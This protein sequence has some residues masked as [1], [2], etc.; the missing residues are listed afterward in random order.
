MI[1][2]RI[3]E[4]ES[5]LAKLRQR[6]VAQLREELARLESYLD[7]GPRPAKSSGKGWAPD[8]SDTP[9]PSTPS[10]SRKARGGRKRPSDAEVV[11]RLRKA[12]VAAGSEGISARAAALQGNINY[13]RAIKAMDSSFVKS[14]AGRSSRYTIK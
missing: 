6:K 14:G 3:A 10:I 1:D 5:E 8:L 9:A 2:H 4:L 12:V 13:L 11:A 7:G